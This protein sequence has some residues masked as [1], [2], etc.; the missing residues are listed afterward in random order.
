MSH[1]N[2][3]ATSEL[4]GA[5]TSASINAKRRRL[6]LA[7]TIGNVLEW[8]D[9][10]VYGLLALTIAKLFFPAESEL[11]SL[12]LSMAS[13]GVGLA[14]RPVGAIVLGIY[15]DR[16]GRKAALSLTIFIMALGTGLI[17]VAPTYERIGVWAPILIVFAR[18]LQ[19]FSCGGEP[20]GAI[21]L[22]VESASPRH[23]GLY[24]S[25]QAASPAAGFLLGALTTLAVTLMMSPAEI[26]S[27][28][29]RWPFVFGLLIAPV[30]LY[31]RSELDEPELFL[32]AR[33][34][35]Q[36]GATADTLRWEGQPMLIGLGV[37][38]LFFVS[39]YLLLVY[40]PIFAVKQLE[41]PFSAALLASVVAASVVFVFTPIAAAISDRIGRKPMLELASL[42][43]LL[44][45]Y[46]A[47][48]LI[49]TRPSVVVLTC[50]QSAFGL[51]LAMYGGPVM[52][53]LAE[54]F[55]TR[56]RATAVAVVYNVAAAAIGGFAPFIVTWLIAATGDP[57]APAFYLI[58][59]AVSAAPRYFGC[60]IGMTNRC[61]GEVSS[62][63]DLLPQR[64]SLR[65]RRC[66]LLQHVAH[67][68]RSSLSNAA[69][70][71]T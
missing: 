70:I 2:L 15:A 28:G 35:S 44:L 5:Q 52:S 64:P 25:W 3:E 71:I 30:G 23:R 67:R 55:P 11:A 57:R 46:P 54:L 17:A 7:A 27:G 24:A 63:T 10:L 8:Y 38:V 50:V 19:G 51:L 36:G 22:L 14:M 41:L 45:A 48:V 6:V 65:D 37:S 43:Y 61:V 56:L 34:A 26:E 42:G 59:A 40:M 12:L 9:F 66:R 60:G 21:A 58:V 53:V 39:A 13:F 18:L 31:I 20:G 33:D 47:F 62:L 1:S 69:I 32:K 68:R 16:V 49:T 4:I 29:W